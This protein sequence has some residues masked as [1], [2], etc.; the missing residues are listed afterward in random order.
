MYRDGVRGAFLAAALVMMPIAAHAQGSSHA[1][2]IRVLRSK[3]DS[4]EPQI[5]RLHVIDSLWE[6]SVQR[7][8]LARNRQP[9]D[10]LMAGPFKVIG[11]K[12]AVTASAAVARRA[13]MNVRPMFQGVEQDANGVVLLVSMDGMRKDLAAHVTPASQVVTILPDARELWQDAFE[14]AMTAVL[15]KRLPPSVLAWLHPGGIG[16]DD[17]TFSFRMLALNA[18]DDSTTTRHTG[19]LDRNIEM[20]KQQLGLIPGEQQAEIRQVIRGQFFSYTVRHA[21]PGAIAAASAAPADNTSYTTAIEH[22]GG[23]GIDTLVARWV[24]HVA[25]DSKHGFERPLANI[26]ATLLWLVVF[27]GLAMR[28]SRWRLG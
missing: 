1:E 27:C 7:D 2:Q 14:T 21:R 18:R 12:R 8:Q 15:A 28:S 20:C 23:A 13:W 10:S 24:D 5:R 6:D 3:I 22:I 16:I 4:L 26:A 25:R 17:P 11:Y 19:C 9:I